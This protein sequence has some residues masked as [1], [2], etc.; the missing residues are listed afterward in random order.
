MSDAVLK[1]LLSEVRLLRE[2]ISEMREDAE[3]AHQKIDGLS[4]L[5]TMLAGATMEVE[6]DGLEA[7]MDDIGEDNPQ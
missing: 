3:L 1:Q 4:V 7:M 2:E 5:M 6:R